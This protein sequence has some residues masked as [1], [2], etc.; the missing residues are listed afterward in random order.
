VSVSLGGPLLAAVVLLGAAA[1]A[2]AAELARR[3][4]HPTAPLFRVVPSRLPTP[5]AR[6]FRDPAVLAGSAM[7]IAACALAP[8]PAAAGA[9]TAAGWLLLGIAVC[10]ERTLRIP[11]AFSATGV[12]MGLALAGIEGGGREVIARAAASVAAAACLW[13]LARGAR[14][15]AGREALGAGD[16]G[17]V[18]F[19]TTLL[20][21]WA[22]LDAVLAGALVA[23]AWAGAAATRSRRRAGHPGRGGGA[24]PFGACLVL[25]SFCVIV[26]SGI[27]GAPSA[28]AVRRDVL[29]GH[30]RP[31]SMT[32]TA[33]PAATNQGGASNADGAHSAAPPSRGGA[34]ISEGEL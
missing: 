33:H 14:A 4:R 13:V 7:P 1:G 12:A 23:L 20:G 24:V 34:A 8:T 15:L 16:H 18:A 9:A 29:L 21:P 19:L 27:P 5:T 10:D 2:A 22:A 17:V 3:V 25:G 32:R 28:E 30:P 31:P 11:H 26:A 6:A